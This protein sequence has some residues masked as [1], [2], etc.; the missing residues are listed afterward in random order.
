[1][2]WVQL[3]LKGAFGESALLLGPGGTSV[4]VDV[5]NDSHDDDVLDAVEAWTGERSVDW[6]VLTHFHADHLGAA[7]GLVDELEVRQGV[8]SRGL[9]HLDDANAAEVAGL[10]SWIARGVEHRPLCDESGCPGL[11]QPLDL[12]EGAELRW[13]AADGQDAAGPLVDGELTENARSLAGLVDWGDF[14]LLFGG[15]LTGG[16]RDTPDVETPLAAALDPVE[17]MQANH[18]GLPSSNNEAWLDAA[19]PDDGEDRQVL[20]GAGPGYIE[21]PHPDALTAWAPR[22]GQ[23]FVWAPDRGAFAGSHD[24]FRSVRGAVEV[25]VA[26]DGGYGVRAAEGD[27]CV[28]EGFV[29][30]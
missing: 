27:R 2:R 19:L 30:R 20:V 21:A 15:D 7:S 9:V 25:R 8:I 10:E 28:V 26:A 6:V 5:G 13:L 3:H 1:M 14:Q 29:A 11:G 24:R 4:L 17:V 22:L 12:G 18:H 23:G 16:G